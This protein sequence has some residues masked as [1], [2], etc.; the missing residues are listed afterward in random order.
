MPYDQA[1]NTIFSFQGTRNESAWRVAEIRS[2][3]PTLET[4]EE[5][6]KFTRVHKIVLQILHLDLEKELGR[7][8]SIIDQVDADGKSSQWIG[9]L[10]ISA[11][12]GMKESPSLSE[13]CRFYPHASKTSSTAKRAHP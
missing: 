6:R 1:C 13:S 10:G 2:L 5:R 12:L 9:V 11:V 8:R 3:F 7:D 4:L